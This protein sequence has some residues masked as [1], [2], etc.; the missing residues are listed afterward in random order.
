MK[1]FLVIK[2]NNDTDKKSKHVKLINCYFVPHFLQNSMSV[3]FA[4]Y[5]IKVPN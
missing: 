5:T 3:H 2:S 4:S 1:T